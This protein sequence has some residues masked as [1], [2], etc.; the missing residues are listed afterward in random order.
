MPCLHLRKEVSI[1]TSF[2]KVV[3]SVIRQRKNSM[4]PFTNPTHV[5]LASMS[6]LSSSIA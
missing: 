2:L 5:K 1:S 4:P 6:Y 3:K